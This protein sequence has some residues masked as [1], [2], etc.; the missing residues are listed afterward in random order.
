MQEDVL[1]R[2]RRILGE[3]HPDTIT[4]AGNLAATLWALGDYPGACTIEE[5]VLARRRRIQG[6][7]H[8]DTITAAAS[9]AATLWAL[10]D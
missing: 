3:D 1:A 5:D 4:A 7:D 2:R 6:E 8:P 9:L 10:G